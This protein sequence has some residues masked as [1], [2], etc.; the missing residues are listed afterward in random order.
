MDPIA[1]QMLA[2]MEE[3]GGYSEMAAAFHPDLRTRVESLVSGAREMPDLDLFAE[4]LPETLNAVARELQVRAAAEGQSPYLVWARYPNLNWP[5]PACMPIPRL[6]RLL[7]LRCAD[8]CDWCDRPGEPS[9]ALLASAGSTVAV[10]AFCSF[11]RVV[12]DGECD[13]DLYWVDVS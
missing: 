10:F 12:L 8:R 1:D 13:A 7:V 9:S 4:Q 6:A 2:A 11:C 5:V 3:A